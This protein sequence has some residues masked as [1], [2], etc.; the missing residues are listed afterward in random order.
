MRIA[1]IGGTGLAGRHT[2]EVGRPTRHDADRI[3]GETQR[4]R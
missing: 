1:V 3:S 2:V 4:R